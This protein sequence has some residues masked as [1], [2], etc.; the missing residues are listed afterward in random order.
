MK[1]KSKNPLKRP[2]H[3]HIE[4][5]FRKQYCLG[6]V[7]GFLFLAIV[8]SDGKLVG[9]MRDAYAQ[10]YGMLGTYLREETTRTPVTVA[11]AR[12]PAIASK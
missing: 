4:Y 12:I 3:L 9:M 7:L 8:K 6:I 10:G 11:I 5:F 2:L 1:T